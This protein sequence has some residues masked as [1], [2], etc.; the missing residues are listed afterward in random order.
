MSPPATSTVGTVSF[1]APSHGGRRNLGRLAGMMT[2]ACVAAVAAFSAPASAAPPS[3]DSRTAPQE[4][5]RL[6]A[7]VSGTTVD[8][9]LE[10][11][12]PFSPVGPIKNSVWFSF[13]VS[14]SRDLLVALDAAGD[15]DAVVDL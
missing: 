3:N 2:L 10:Q 9:T 7:L 6:P 8:A 14:S 12:E 15:M 5:G 4:L 11:D 13:S 1:T